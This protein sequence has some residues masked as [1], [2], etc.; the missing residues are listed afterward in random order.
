M[1]IARVRP[2]APR[3]PEK[4]PRPQKQSAFGHQKMKH[5]DKRKGRPS[6]RRVRLFL[7]DHEPDL[8]SK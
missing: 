6:K 1:R 7:D 8:G 4:Q 3:T 5:N 2:I